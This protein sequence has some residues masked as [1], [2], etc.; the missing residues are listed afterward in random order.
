MMLKRLGLLLGLLLV[1]AC[2]ANQQ[3]AANRAPTAVMDL[4]QR[5]ADM[6]LMQWYRHAIIENPW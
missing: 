5:H 4:Q 2:Q 1:A 6:A 3:S